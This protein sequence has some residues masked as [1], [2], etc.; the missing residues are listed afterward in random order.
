MRAFLA[1][2][3]TA[4]VR[5]RLESEQR[6][7]GKVLSGVRWVRE[8]NM[9]LTL[10]FLGEL[11]DH[12]VRS[13]CQSVGQ[14]CQR[15]PPGTLGIADLG[16]FPQRGPAKTLW[17]GAADRDGTLTLLHEG[18]V[19]AARGL[20]LAVE[21]RAFAGHLTLGRS[22][23]GIGRRRVLEALENRGRVEL[24]TMKVGSCVLFQSFLEAGGPRYEAVQR[25]RLGPGS[26]ED[27]G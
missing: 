7:L 1:I 13:L 9:H 14:L 10:L 6:R 18:L 8:E 21:A 25:W 2:E 23:R 27:N 24:G 12:R 19:D 3:L 5:Q 15:V 20:G 11:A 26:R 4:E 16:C 22:K 17:V